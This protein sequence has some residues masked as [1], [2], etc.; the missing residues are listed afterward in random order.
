MYIEKYIIILKNVIN[1]WLL[2]YNSKLKPN[3]LSYQYKKIINYYLH[4][5]TTILYTKLFINRY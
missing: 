4:K 5:S 3:I 1:I 2:L